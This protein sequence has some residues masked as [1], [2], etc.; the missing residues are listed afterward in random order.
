MR[1]D[2]HHGCTVGGSPQE[3]SGC[4][5]P[6]IGDSSSAPPHPPLAHT[7]KDYNFHLRSA[8]HIRECLEQK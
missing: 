8:L 2:D 5:Q 6:A 3:N 4:F 7:Y 1:E